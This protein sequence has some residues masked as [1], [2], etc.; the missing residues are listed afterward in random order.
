MD[1]SSV[2]RRPTRHGRNRWD[3]DTTLA[4]VNGVATVV[5]GVYLATFSVIVTSI[6]AVT[7]IAVIVLVLAFRR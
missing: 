5:Q 2:G 6:M 4:I 3:A 7:S 1:E